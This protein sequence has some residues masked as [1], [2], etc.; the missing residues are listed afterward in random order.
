MRCSAVQCGA[1]Q[2]G[3]CST[4]VGVDC[5]CVR[6]RR[7][8]T[9]C[10]GGSHI[11][12]PH[13]ALAGGPPQAAARRVAPPLPL[14]TILRR[15]LCAAEKPRPLNDS[16]IDV[17]CGRCRAERHAMEQWALMP[18][19]RH[20]DAS[21]SLFAC[22]FVYDIDLAIHAMN[23]HEPTVKTHTSSIFSASEMSSSGSGGRTTIGGP[24]GSG[25]GG[26][27]AAPVPLAGPAF[28]SSSD[29]ES[30]SVE[31]AMAGQ[32]QHSLRSLQH[33][34]RNDR[35]HGVYTEL[36]AHAGFPAW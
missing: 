9:G 23:R 3:C 16:Y 14:A 17:D 2:G 6:Q 30:S 10:C 1:V 32:L 36:A 21:Q 26:G 13:G 7:G 27:G 33:R 8:V 22:V 35:D 25:G 15:F 34:L 4:P 29:A 19:C 11:V 18:H 24:A 20:A 12:Q 31:H 5:C 28:S